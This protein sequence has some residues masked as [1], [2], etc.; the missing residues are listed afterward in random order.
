[1]NDNAIA[2]I[3]IDYELLILPPLHLRTVFLDRTKTHNRTLSGRFALSNFGHPFMFA[4]RL[5]QR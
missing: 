4:R 2:Y 1:M 5:E 3:I